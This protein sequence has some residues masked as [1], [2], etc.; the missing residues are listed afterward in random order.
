[1]QQRAP[2]GFTI[3]ELMVSL[4]ILAV[5]SSQLLLVFQ[6]Q[7]KAY[8]ANERILD[9][10]EDAR[11]VMDL[12]SH[13]AR[14]AGFMVPRFAAVSSIDGGTGGP[15]TLC[16]SDSNRI[17]QAILDSATQPFDRSRPAAPIPA[18]QNQVTVVA[19]DLD[20]DGD[21]VND[22]GVG[23][24]V[25]VADTLNTF[26]A[27]ITAINANELTLDRNFT[28][29]FG[30]GARVVPAV[31]YEVGA[32]G[33]LGLTRNGLLLSP[34]VEDLQA[35]FAVDVNGDGLIDPNA[36]GG[37]FPLDSLNGFDSSRLLQVRLTV[38]TRATQASPDFT[39]GFAAAANRVAGPADSF[40]RRRFIASVR[41]RNLGNP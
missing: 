19:G 7:K 5:V 33:G 28:V 9:V 37:E 18:A 36:A 27:L 39:G 29:G 6:S 35:E 1:M 4:V 10:Q 2:S 23:Q 25:I 11:L 16:V 14:M 26:C 8:M 21:T 20:I 30:T 31:M 3:I 32:G 38:T 24:A 40:Q 41:P 34:E 12:V 17:N 15:D 13:E 22:F